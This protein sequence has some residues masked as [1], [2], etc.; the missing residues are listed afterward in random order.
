METNLSPTAP[1]ALFCWI[2]LTGIAAL[3]LISLPH[4]GR[5]SVLLAGGIHIF[6]LFLLTINAYFLGNIFLSV[7][8][9]DS[10]TKSFTI[11]EWIFLSL[12]LGLGT[13]ALLTFLFGYVAPY[14]RSFYL[15]LHVVAFVVFLFSYLP[16]HKARSSSKNTYL[17]L[18]RLAWGE[19]LIWGA[20]GLFLFYYALV[21]GFSLEGTD[22]QTMH[23]NR[24]IFWI[25]EGRYQPFVSGYTG[26]P[27]QK[28]GMQYPLGGLLLL[29]V[30]LLGDLQ[31]TGIFQVLAMSLTAL[32]VFAFGTRLFS[33]S[34]GK[35]AALMYLSSPVIFR[36]YM[37]DVSDYPLNVSLF[38]GLCICLTAAIRGHSRQWLRVALVFGGLLLGV[39]YYALLQILLV[40]AIATPFLFQGG[41]LG[42]LIRDI[43]I[44]VLLASVPV[45]H[46]FLVFGNP[47]WPYLNELFGGVPLSPDY[48]LFVSTRKHYMLSSF[49]SIDSTHFQIVVNRLF[50][51]LFPSL[52]STF[53][54]SPLMLPFLVL[55]I[56][57]TFKNRLYAIP[58]IFSVAFLAI[59]LN[60]DSLLFHKY[61]FII[62]AG[63]A[64]FAAKAV[65]EYTGEGGW[66]NQ[67]ITMIIGIAVIAFAAGALTVH[68]NHLPRAVAYNESVYKREP[69]RTINDL[70][71][72]SKVFMNISS[73]DLRELRTYIK[74]QIAQEEG[75]LMTEDWHT[76]FE[77]YKNLGITHYLVQNPPK[78]PYPYPATPIPSI[79]FD[80]ELAEYIESR[81]IIFERNV[82]QRE[83]YLQSA[84]TQ[85]DLGGG[86]ILYE[87]QNNSSKAD[88]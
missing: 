5:W 85:K 76:L 34:A 16:K 73:M 10:R 50:S 33:Q 43:W 39:K 67:A 23:L 66:R 42:Y 55:S 81:R 52:R 12:T 35:L 30:S 37:N 56:F 80:S 15:T 51:E 65:L 47:I 87:L 54:P 79:Y 2:L 44:F 58:L 40:M 11:L 1:R 31:S 22:S 61:F 14:S 32:G 88:L 70:P 78:F 49:I 57:L 71:P 3:F 72:E 53:A 19:A 69:V 28:S 63:I 45:L 59:C 9:C 24:V 84:A 4:A 17:P 82:S 86:Y 13:L 48:D 60:P 8:T 75:E 68:Q 36:Y 38:L 74:T 83:Q 62:M 46:N 26:M 6:A 25:E 18:E 41:L 7:L 29:H 21:Q 27:L 77:Y 20:I 64:P